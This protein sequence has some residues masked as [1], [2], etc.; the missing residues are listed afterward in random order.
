M[1]DPTSLI[2]GILKDYL[3]NILHFVVD[4]LFIGSKAS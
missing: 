4:Q 1:A 3:P 2:E